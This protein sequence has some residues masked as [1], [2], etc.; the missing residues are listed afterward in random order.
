MKQKSHD[1][2]GLN[3]SGASTSSTTNTIERKI[4]MEEK[5]SVTNSRSSLNNSHQQQQNNE[6]GQLSVSSEHFKGPTIPSI[7][8]SKSDGTE[9]LDDS[10]EGRC[11]V[12]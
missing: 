10:T 5:R 8:S 2:K 1:S 9:S 6:I 11:I 7:N 3:T 4:S 12:M